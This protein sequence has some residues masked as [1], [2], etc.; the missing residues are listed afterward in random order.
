MHDVIIQK[1]PYFTHESVAVLGWKEGG[2]T[3][4]GWPWSDQGSCCVL[5]LNWNRISIEAA[6][7]ELR[8]MLSITI[9]LKNI[10]V[11][12]VNVFGSTAFYILW[13]LKKQA[14]LKSKYS[15]VSHTTFKD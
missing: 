1:V 4:T 6:L 8:V 5:S 3:D 10:T 9:L 11:E 12:S 2:Q 14:L 15:T 13:K 7:V